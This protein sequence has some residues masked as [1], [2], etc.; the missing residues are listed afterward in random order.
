MH[1]PSLP[2]FTPPRKYVC[3]KLSRPVDYSAAGS[4]TPMK[5]SSNTIGNK[6]L[7]LPAQPPAPSPTPNVVMLKH[8][9]K[10][11]FGQIILKDFKIQLL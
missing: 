11:H 7:D 9:R 3:Q 8:G 10:T 1:G 6:T 4:I 5:N 2:L